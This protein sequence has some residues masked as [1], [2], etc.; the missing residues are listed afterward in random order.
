MGD[1]AYPADVLGMSGAEMR[2]LGHK[3]VDRIVDRLENRNAEA[4]IKTGC[5][6]ALR[7]T[8]GGPL[9]ENPTDADT[10]IDLLA[11][12]ALNHQQHGDHPRYFARIPGPASFAGMLADW[13]GTGFNT[14]A[15]SWAGGSGPATVEVIAVEWLAELIGMP[16][17]TEGVFMSGGSLANLTALATARHEVGRGVVY[18]TSQ[19]H[20]SLIRDLRVLGWE[21]ESI[22]WVQTDDRWRM[23][24][25]NL[26]ET[27]ERDAEAGQKPA[28]VIASAG[29]TN[30]GAIDP[31]KE[32]AAVCQENGIWFHID[33]S[34]GAPAAMAERARSEFEGMDLADSLALDPHKWLF[35]PYDI[36]AC[37]VTRPGAL[38]RR[39]AV[40]PEYLKDA[41]LGQKGKGAVNF[42]NRSLEL[43]RRS[44]ALKVWLS[45]RTYGAGAFRAAVNRGIE[46]AEFAE[47]ELRRHPNQWEVVTPA[48]IGIVCF[49][50]KDGRPNL[51]SDR[52]QALADSGFACVTS[53][54]LGGRSV[55][56]LCCIN[57]LTTENDIR[58]TLC[59][60]L[61]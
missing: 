47:E 38:E 29:T 4:A 58:E 1:Q 48:Q 51:H 37:L 9:P 26:K 39:H 22:R 31:L 59:R 20:S 25:R 11:D 17:H 42:G 33:G 36:G 18:V 5:P 12:I 40:T 7:E 43:S 46:L 30:T 16:K 55:L 8:L 45:L 6:D 53:T 13:L 28:I 57:P 2:R 49:A 41:H 56:R 21:D 61:P 3:V 14:I 23:C 54:K 19:T 24:V 50:L 15:A 27:L 52:A 34:Y 32:I 60:L 10:S 35:Q 44:R